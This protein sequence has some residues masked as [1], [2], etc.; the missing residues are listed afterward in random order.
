MTKRLRITPQAERDLEELA[1]Y[2]ARD[3][4]EVAQRFQ[5]AAVNTGIGLLEFPEAY[6]VIDLEVGQDLGLRKT[7]V[8]GFKN[9]LLFYVVNEEAVVIQR[10]I[11]GARD[12]PAALREDPGNG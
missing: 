7:T 2:I 10:F 11:H 6:P 3:S 4:I 9:H 1:L 12:L 8:R 5:E